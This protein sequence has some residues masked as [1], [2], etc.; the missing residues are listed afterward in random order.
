MVI[1]LPQASQVLRLQV[2]VTMS[3]LEIFLKTASWIMASHGC[4]VLRTGA[5]MSSFIKE[6]VH[7]DMI[8]DFYTGRLL[9]SDSKPTSVSPTCT[10]RGSDWI[11]AAKSKGSQQHRK[12]EE[13]W[14]RISRAFQ[15]STDWTQLN[16]RPVKLGSNKFLLF[17]V[18]ICP[19]IHK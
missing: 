2:S 1:L 3:G 5:C 10:I 17:H 8:K 16:F 13:V 11:D 14:Y 9:G 7:V 19:S 15:E 4:Q 6:R 12:L 18:V